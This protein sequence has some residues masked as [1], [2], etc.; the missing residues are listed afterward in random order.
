MVN[1]DIFDKWI[2]KT[3]DDISS[4]KEFSNDIHLNEICPL[5]HSSKDLFNVSIQC[6][7]RLHSYLNL[8]KYNKEVVAEMNIEL[9]P[10]NSGNTTIA[11]TSLMDLYKQINLEEDIHINLG[12]P[13]KTILNPTL[14]YYC[15]PLNYLL[16]I[17]EDINIFYSAY[18]TIEEKKSSESFERWISLLLHWNKSE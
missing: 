14:E 9:K 7:Q 1:F 11:S 10:D 16:N 4:S 6:M 8:K 5:K 15:I 3:L 18:R 2:I 12:I 13:N 17:E